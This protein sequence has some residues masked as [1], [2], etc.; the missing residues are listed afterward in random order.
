MDFPDHPVIAVIGAG[1]VGSYYAGRLAQHGSSVHFLFRSDYAAVRR[2]GLTVRS[3]DGDFS[4]P[5]DSIGVYDDPRKMPPADLVIVALKATANDQYEPLISPL[6]HDHSAIL[7]LQNGL[8]NEDR[9]AELF[10][11][12]RILGGLAFVC[13]NR[14]GPGIIYHQAE[15]LIRLGEFGGGASPRAASIAALFNRSNVRCQVL[16][17]LLHG[18]WQKLVWNIPFNGL[19][20]CMDLDTRQL[21]NSAEGSAL[22]E[23]IMREVIAIAAAGG[24]TLSDSLIESMLT[25]TREM[26]AY[27]S[28]MQIDRHEGRPMEVDAILGEPLRAADRAAVPA[29][30]LRMLYRLALIADRRETRDALAI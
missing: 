8:G 9:L 17:S 16:D 13:I 14:V 5:V 20:A 30:L 22:I 18:R 11:A 10:G 6:L 23:Q 24:V 4:L 7:T 25:Q 2:D 19:G 27:R 15:G 26:G 29:P 21:L 12:G 28:S 3:C 1:A